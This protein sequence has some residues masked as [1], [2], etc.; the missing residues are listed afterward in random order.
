MSNQSI[1]DTIITTYLSALTEFSPSKKRH[2]LYRAYVATSREDLGVLLKEVA[3][4]LSHTEKELIRMYNDAY[5]K[6]LERRQAELSSYSIRKP[7]DK[8]KL[9]QWQKHI[10]LYIFHGLVWALY[11]LRTLS[12]SDTPPFTI[13]VKSIENE[14]FS[15]VQFIRYATVSA[16][17]IVFLSRN[18]GLFNI[19]EQFSTKF[20]KIFEDSPHKDIVTFTNYIYG[21]THIIIGDSNFYTQDILREKYGWVKNALDLYQEQIFDQLSL[22][23]NTEVALCYRMFGIEN[24]EYIQK[25]SQRLLANFYDG[26]IHRET[27]NSMNF[28]EHTN[29]IALLLF[30]FDRIKFSHHA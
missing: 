19:E 27:D 4:S 7:N 10:S 25:V 30:N 16:V 2:F 12:I 23:I 18:I 3:I 22:D 13:D 21:L 5:E 1:T 17:N 28:A 15:D 14:L 9:E 29:A 26:Y 24:N 6:L 20:Q 8:K 11:Y